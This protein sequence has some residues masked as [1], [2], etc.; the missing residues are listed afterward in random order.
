MLFDYFYFLLFIDEVEIIYIFFF[1]LILKFIC[2]LIRVAF[3]TLFER[4]ILSFSQFRIGPNKVIFKGILQPLLDGVKLLIKE[5]FFPKKIIFWGI[6]LGP[7]LG[8]LVILF[9]WVI[10]KTKNFFLVRFYSIIYIIVLIGLG[11]YSTLISGWRR[12]SK[13][14]RIGRIRSCSQSISYEISLIFFIFFILIFFSSLFIKYNFF[15]LLFWTFLV[16]WLRCVAETNRAPFDFREGERELISGFNIEFGSSGFV[17]LFLAE[18]G[19][20]IFFSL[21]LCFL[22]FNINFFIFLIILLSFIFIR[23]V[24][25]RFRYDILINLTWTKFLPISL[26]FILI[27]FFLF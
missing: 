15:I 23:R 7:F 6:I 1:S 16:F 27:C 24:Y 9:L 13:F 19:I 12:T 26:F 8:F 14:A 11:V 17:F 4:K 21:L 10:I 25:P 18:Y 22:Y 3:V 5:F 20:I 2:V